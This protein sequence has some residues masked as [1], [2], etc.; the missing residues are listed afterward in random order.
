MKR[1][2]G[3]VFVGK[4][5]ESFNGIGCPGNVETLGV[6]DGFL[7]SFDCITMVLGVSREF[8]SS[9]SWEFLFCS[10]CLRFIVIVKFLQNVTSVNPITI[11][12]VDTDPILNKRASFEKL[13]VVIC[14][15]ITKEI[16]QTHNIIT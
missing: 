10:F 15:D 12:V 1:A 16:N 4:R 9:L 3:L 7:I 5:T 11:I 8:T 14:K 6:S 13:M 2:V